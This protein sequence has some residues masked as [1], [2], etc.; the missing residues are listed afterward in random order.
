MFHHV[1]FSGSYPSLRI[2]LFFWRSRLDNLDAKN[3]Q[4]KDRTSNNH[5]LTVFFL[6][7][8]DVGL[9]ENRV[10]PSPLVNHHCH[11]YSI[12]I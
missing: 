2:A 7:T 12:P 10:A 8:Q 6:H 4:D 1:L 5:D 9:S 11:H 3:R